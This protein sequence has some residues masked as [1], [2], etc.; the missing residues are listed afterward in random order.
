MVKIWDLTSLHRGGGEKSPI[1]RIN[2]FLLEDVCAFQ[3]SKL[4]I[5][6]FLTMVLQAGASGLSAFLIAMKREG[7]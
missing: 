4:E 6:K 5:R 7:L 2:R 1:G 3:K